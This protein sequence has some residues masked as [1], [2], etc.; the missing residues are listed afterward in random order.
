MP[1]IRAENMGKKF[2]LRHAL[3]GP[4]EKAW[5]R[6]LLRREDRNDFWA[7][8]EL[9]FAVSPGE[10]VGVIGPNGSGKSTLLGILA[11]TMVPST[12]SLRVQGSISS[13]LELGSGFHPY[14][15]GRENIFLN[16]SILGM[17]HR[18]IEEKY[19]WIVDFSELGDFIESPLQ[20]YSSGMAVRLGFSVAAAANPDVLIV[21]E[22]L[23]V[24]DEAFQKKS[25]QKMRQFKQENKTIVVVSHDMNLVRDFCDRVIYL[26]RGRIVCDG[27]TDQ[28][29]SCYIKDVQEQLLKGGAALK[30]KHEWGTR[31]AEI[32]GALLR[33]EGDGEEDQF[34]AGR[35][36][37][38][39]VSFRARLPISNPVFGFAVHDINHNLCFGSNTQLSG[40][41]ISRIEGEG[42]IKFRLKKLSLLTGRYLLS[43]SIHS[44]D[45]LT[46]YH[47]QEYFYPFAVI[48][49]ERGEGLFSI[50]VEWDY[51][52]LPNQSKD[53]TDDA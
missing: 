16:G 29:V 2:R 5:F 38:V 45:H 12:G 11:G 22:V 39:E 41:P 3:D 23:A 35:D 51:G 18:E 25:G 53:D 10:T 17:S 15:T 13:L 47:R 32:T 34:E 20:T 4:R 26:R 28:A 19:D 44:V 42:R 40:K 24:G 1:V 37:V 48:S 31:E 36:L 27:P 7:L 30:V 49:A 14:L 6:R 21:D 52:D 46:N 43:L 9:N 50:P 8:R 33:G